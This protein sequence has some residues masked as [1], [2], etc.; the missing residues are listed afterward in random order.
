LTAA[1]L[2]K[3]EIEIGFH[4]KYVKGY[5]TILEPSAGKTKAFLKHAKPKLRR[6]AQNGP[7]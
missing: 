7:G 6:T 3:F 2:K 1:R 4:V 5:G